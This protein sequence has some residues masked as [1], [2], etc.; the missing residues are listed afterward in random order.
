M[1]CHVHSVHLDLGFWKDG[2]IFLSETSCS[3]L[4]LLAAGIR[5]DVNVNSMLGTCVVS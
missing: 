5:K 2:C 4:S 3:Y 1:M